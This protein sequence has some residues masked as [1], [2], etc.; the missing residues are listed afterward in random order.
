[1]SAVEHGSAGAAVH[2]SFAQ[3]LAQARTAAHQPPALPRVPLV[4]EGQVV[5]SVAPG[6]LET[7]VAQGPLAGGHRLVRKEQA[8]QWARHLDTAPGQGTQ[9]L[10]ALADVLRGLDRCGPWRNEQ[11]AVPNGEGEVVATVER[12]AVRVLGIATRAVHLVG[13]APDGRMW[14]QLRSR[15]KPNN[16]GMWDTLM[17]GMV[18]AV[19]TLDQAL[20]RETWEEA[21]LHVAALAGVAHGGHVL[22]SRPSREGG[23]IGLMVERIDW[24]LATVPDGMEPANQDGE[25]ERFE[26][27]DMGEVQHRV[28]RGEFTQEAGLVIGG[29]VD[30]QAA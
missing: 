11:L 15:T 6:V 28:A 10:N 24:F 29:F 3:W 25:V 5:G 18:A 2:K 30:A 13:L 23:G 1:M 27:L 17:G 14:V 26:L 19:D 16:P 12:G 4:V 8:G 9:A 7:V 21:G 20:A 22:F